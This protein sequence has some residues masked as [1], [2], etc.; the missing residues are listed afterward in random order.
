[1]TQTGTHAHCWIVML[2]Q[3]CRHGK[4]C[5]ICRE[6]F[7]LTL[8]LVFEAEKEPRGDNVSEKSSVLLC[9]QHSVH[10]LPWP[11]CG[12]RPRTPLTAHFSLRK[13][14]MFEYKGR[15]QTP[16]SAPN[17]LSQPLESQTF[18]VQA[19]CTCTF[20]TQLESR[21]F[22]AHSLERFFLVHG[23]GTAYWQGSLVPSLCGC[24]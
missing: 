24:G 5:G 9:G 7:L 16:Q 13:V 12:S 15:A 21:N 4:S 23:F 1:M 18:S 19:K 22:P 20:A 6:T 8:W 3:S 2:P 17:A 11:G 14:A 10:G